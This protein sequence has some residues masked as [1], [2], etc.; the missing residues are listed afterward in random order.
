[1]D[2]K[3][4]PTV[5]WSASIKEIAIALAKFQGSVQNVKKEAE[6]PYFHSKYASFDSIVDA[7]RKPL[8]DNGLSYTQWP[9]GDTLVTILLH[10]SGEF[11][12]ASIA[13]NPKDKAPQS[14]GSAITYMRR[15]V[16]SSVLGLATEEDDDGNQATGEPKPGAKTTVKKGKNFDYYADAVDRIGKSKTVAE[17]TTLAERIDK[18]EEFTDT[19]KDSLDKLIGNRITELEGHTQ[20]HT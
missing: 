10:T 20:S 5:E 1:M 7:I 8:S 11:M 16:L 3:T 13:L 2:T 6:N 18:S 12:K 15:Y 4:T 14:V 19:Q 9:L 17:V